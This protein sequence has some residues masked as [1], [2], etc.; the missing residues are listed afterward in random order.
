M[1]TFERDGNQFTYRVAGIAVHDGAVLLQTVESD[2]FW[3]LPGGRCEMNE[4]AAAAL[5]R[6]M[7]EEIEL[8]PAVESLA[9]VVENFFSYNGRQCHELGLYF[10]MSFPEGSPVYSRG[11]SFIGRE[12]DVTLHYRWVP[13]S[14]LDAIIIK[15]S[16]IGRRLIALSDIV[17]HIVHVDGA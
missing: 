16:F 10:I 6:E 9:W 2:D 4:D 7:I 11:E 5:R 8:E 17:E 15:P 1:I 13:L 14:E 12:G 3:V